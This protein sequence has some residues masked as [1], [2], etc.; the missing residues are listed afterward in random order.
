MPAAG[1]LSAACAGRWGW[2]MD[3]NPLAAFY[4]ALQAA[5]VAPAS[6][7]AL[8]ADGLL[9]RHRIEQDK[10][11]SLNGWHVLHLDNP[12]SGAGGSWKT[13]ARAN[14][15][16]KRMQSLTTAERETLRLRIEEDKRRAQAEQEARHREAAQRGKWAWEHAKPASASHEYLQRK[17]IAPGIARQR[18]GAL[19]LPVQDFTGQLWGLQFIAP[20]SGKRFLSGMKKSGCYIPIG[21]RLDDSRAI[22]LVEGWATGMT[23]QAMKPTVQVAACCD[24]GNLASVA[25][26]A[27]R[28]WPSVSLVVCP[29]FDAIGTTKGRDAAIAARARILPPPAQIPEGASD[30]NDVAAARRQGVAS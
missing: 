16:A 15:C 24:A 9:H 30:W 17:G 2:D 14:W 27:R 19:V 21:G 22:Y 26:E 23:I 8:V 12:A 11:G 18:G 10:P 3:N 1:G 5:G 25:V 29:D 13:G 20:D 4:D 7:S 28:R 6:P